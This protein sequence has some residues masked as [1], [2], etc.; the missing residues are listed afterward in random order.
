[1]QLSRRHIGQLM[2]GFC[3]FVRS[4]DAGVT[5]AEIENLVFANLSLSLKAVREK[6]ADCRRALPKPYMV[7][8]I[9]VFNPPNMS[10]KLAKNLLC[11]CTSAHCKKSRSTDRL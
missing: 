8:L 10:Q 6:L 1:M 7:S 3:N 11:A 9:M 4:R 2:H 5:D